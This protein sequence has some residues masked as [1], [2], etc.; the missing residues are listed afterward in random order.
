M[1]TRSSQKYKREGRNITKR[2]F[3]TYILLGS[4]SVQRHPKKVGAVLNLLAHALHCHITVAHAV[5][6]L[7]DARQ[8]R[9][10]PPS[11]RIWVHTAHTLSKN[12]TGRNLVL[13]STRFPFF[14]T[15]APPGRL[16]LY[17]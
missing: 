8:L 13:G 2:L 6:K 1:T 14:L 17:E 3:T 15:N 9:P 16:Q 4:D 5:W 11:Y 12:N 10:D 7:L